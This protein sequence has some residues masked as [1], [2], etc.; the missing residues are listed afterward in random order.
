MQ[1]LE[2]EH[3]LDRVEPNWKADVELRETQCLEPHDPP[4][5]ARQLAVIDDCLSTSDAIE[6]VMRRFALSAK[7]LAEWMANSQFASRLRTTYESYARGRCPVVVGLQSPTWHRRAVLT[8][9]RLSRDAQ[10]RELADR[11]PR[12][13][14]R[15]LLALDRR[16]GAKNREF[17]RFVRKSRPRHAST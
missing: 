13:L 8:L 14:D 5:S 15:T 11:I 1:N 4:L 12:P 6:V 17:P 10:A 9:M 7:R 16:P 3:S 2:P